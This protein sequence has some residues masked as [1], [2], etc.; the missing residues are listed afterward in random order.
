MLKWSER[1]TENYVYS[2]YLASYRACTV[3]VLIVLL[4]SGKAGDL[5][6]GLWWKQQPDGFRV[7]SAATILTKG[8]TICAIT[9]MVTSLGLGILF[10]KGTTSSV[11]EDSPAAEQ[12]APIAAPEAAPPSDQAPAA[13]Q[14]PAQE[15]APAERNP[16]NSS[17]P[18]WWNWQTHHLEGVA[19]ERVCGFE[20]RLRHHFSVVVEKQGPTV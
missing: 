18:E 7:R 20:S 6:L 15:A 1:R 8:T 10:T 9:F 5:G 16:K 14:E 11:L 12:A 2:I 19:L 4:Q 17:V 3:L 13:D